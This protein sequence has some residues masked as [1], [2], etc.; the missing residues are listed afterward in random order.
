MPHAEITIVCSAPART[1]LSGVEKN[2]LA[3]ANTV[4]TSITIVKCY[5]LLS[6]HES[7]DV[8]ISLAVACCWVYFVVMSAKGR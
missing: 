4:V 5:R 3:K 8:D 2:A 6:L 1:Q 7:L